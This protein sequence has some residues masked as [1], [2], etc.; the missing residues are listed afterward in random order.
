MGKADVEVAM[1]MMDP[2][3]C[4]RR[5]IMPNIMAR[6]NYTKGKATVQS[7]DEMMNEAVQYY[8]YHFS[9][10][11]CEGVTPPVD[12]TRGN[13]WHLLEQ[14]YQGG[15]QAAARAAMRGLNGGLPSIY[16]CITEYFSKE[17]EEQYFNHVI[18]ECVNVMD[19]DDI[20]EL[21]QQYIQRYGSYLDGANMP[22]AEYLV[23][24]YRD[25]IKQHAKIVEHIRMRYAR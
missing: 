2:E 12:L 10:V 20:K 15:I 14:H 3:E 6:E 8:N 11:V 5:Y 24:H 17:Q 21:M 13:V 16:D 25:V 23:P 22:K 1:R 19:L 4:S 18:L 7:F 9:K